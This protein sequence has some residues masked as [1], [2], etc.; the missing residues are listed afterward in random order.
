[1]AK[2]NGTHDLDVTVQC[3]ACHEYG[4][5]HTWDVIDTADAKLSERVHFDE[6]LFFYTCPHCHAKIH[7]ESKCLYIDRDKKLLVW[8]IPDPKERVTSKEVQDALGSPSFTTYTC[9]AALTWG[10]W[11]EKIIELEGSYDDRLYEIIK[12]GAYQLLSQEDKE[13]LPLEALA[14]GFIGNHTAVKI[15]LY[16]ITSRDC[17]CSLR[18]LDDRQ[19]DIN[20]VA[21]ENTCKRLSNNTAYTCTLDCQWRM[22]AG[23]T[24][25]KVLICYDD[26]TLLYFIYK[27][28]I[29]IF[30][31][32]FCQ[33]VAIRR[34]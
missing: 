29:N 11:R 7:M 18:A 23:R 24:A 22:L 21:V 8:H 14:G 28:F 1:M 13:R 32:M 30:H 6:N 25:A 5:F 26:I 34:V 16:L 17:F 2:R 19:T 12:Y 31:T 33:L 15:N 4:V 10:E 27:L 20:R 9:R 3:P